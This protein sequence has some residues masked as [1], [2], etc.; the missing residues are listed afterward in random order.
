MNIPRSGGSDEELGAVGVLS[1]VGHGE[2]TSLAVL[3]LEVLVLELVAVNW[4]IDQQASNEA[5]VPFGFTYLTFR[6]CH[7]P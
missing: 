3:E 5:L 6:Q 4:F 2:K 7:H 1:G